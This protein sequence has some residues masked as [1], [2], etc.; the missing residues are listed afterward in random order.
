MVDLP[1]EERNAEQDPQEIRPEEVMR[2]AL[3]G[4][5]FQTDDII[6]GLLLMVS[7]TVSLLECVALAGRVM[8][9][10]LSHDKDA[11]NDNAPS[12]D[13]IPQELSL[14][15][16]KVCDSTNDSLNKKNAH[17]NTKIDYCGTGCNRKMLF[18]IL[19]QPQFNHR[20][21]HFEFKDNWQIIAGKVNLANRLYPLG[22][23]LPNEATM[24]DYL[25]NRFIYPCR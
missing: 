1:P 23:S 22:I 13:V 16:K 11:M 8:E 25:Q 20:L 14:I 18:E 4:T 10:N 5:P 3:G 12:Y 15:L 24:C 6:G 21:K 17:G 7:G 19:T 9:S 2:S